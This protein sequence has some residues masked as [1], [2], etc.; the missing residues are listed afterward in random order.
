MATRNPANVIEFGKF[1]YGA[2]V[3]VYTVSGAT[4]ADSQ[5]APGEDMEKLVEA[6]QMRGTLIGLGS[7][8]AGSFDVAV[9]NSSWDDA[10]AVE[11]AIQGVG[12]VFATA[13]VA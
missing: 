13:T 11:A 8:N 5:V 10:A 2:T 4:G 1:N 3:T 12:G 9:E 6:I 7:F